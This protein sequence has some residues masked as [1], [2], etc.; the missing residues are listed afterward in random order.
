MWLA[1]PGDP[2]H[3]AISMMLAVGGS[4]A[5]LCIEKTSPRAGR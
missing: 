2:N 1:L 3:V 5:A 4:I